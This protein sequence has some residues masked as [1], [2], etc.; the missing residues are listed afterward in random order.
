MV[1]VV[2]VT[3]T[4]TRWHTDDHIGRSRIIAVAVYA[5]CIVVIGEYIPGRE[6]DLEIYC[7]IKVPHPTRKISK[8]LI[9]GRPVK[10]NQQELN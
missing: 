8:P 2:V 5:I 4:T 3:E 9:S 1:S 10:A 7:W 6:S